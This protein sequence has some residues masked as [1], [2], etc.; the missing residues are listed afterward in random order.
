MKRN[1]NTF[2]KSLTRE[3]SMLPSSESDDD[4]NYIA[5]VE[6]YSEYDMEFNDNVDINIINTIQSN[7][8]SSVSNNNSISEFNL[9]VNSS[10]ISNSSL[11][12]IDNSAINLIYSPD[13]LDNI[14]VNGRIENQSTINS[15]DFKSKLSTL[16]SAH[17]VSHNFCDSLLKLLQTQNLQVPST[18]RTL[19]HYNKYKNISTRILSGVEYYFFGVEFMLINT[20]KLYTNNVIDNI[21][22][23]NISINIDGLPIS[24]STNLAMWPILIL[25]LLPIKHVFPVVV[26]LGRKPDNLDFLKETIYELKHILSNGIK[27]NNKI[28]QIKLSS[29]VCDSPAKCFIKNIRQYNGYYGCDKCTQKGFYYKDVN[30]KGGRMTYPL[31]NESLRSDYS[32]RNKT[33]EN[34][35]LNYIDT[36]FLNLDIH[37]INTFTVDYMHCILLGVTKKLIKLWIRT[38]RK[39]CYRLSY[40]NVSQID[41]RI[42]NISKFLPAVFSR[43]PRS[44]FE[45]DKWKATEFRLFLLYIGK[46]VLKNILQNKYYNH[47]I[48][49]SHAVS[50]IICPTYVNNINL[51]LSNKL[52]IHFIED[53]IQYYGSAFPI[54]NVHSL[55][56]IVNDVKSLGCLDNFSAFPFEN[57]LGALK[58]IIKP[59]KNPLKQVINTIYSRISLNISYNPKKIKYN[60]FKYPNN[61]YLLDCSIVCEILEKDISFNIDYDKYHRCRIY[62]KLASYYR[63]PVTLNGQ[64]VNIDSKSINCY[65]VDNTSTRIDFIEKSKLHKQGILFK[66]ENQFI[67]S[68]ILHLQ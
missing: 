5:N 57:Y 22:T 4:V 10:I 64:N 59:G 20:L 50:L 40:S 14:T 41:A 65:L 15:S 35:H 51:V 54:Y 38:N 29:I 28:I 68:P 1:Y 62:E 56:H 61:V 37:M 42:K 9:S 31:L 55:S 24:K 3:L 52:F 39:H 32:F 46:Y 12:L 66:L 45:Y 8:T 27:Y 58:K 26:T 63:I 13:V 34:H 7:V 60:I 67:F 30:E 48:M 36:P 23:I 18:C 17:N 47:F 11:N 16:I 53:G 25:L 33:D 49:F 21:D 43:K 44:L 19:L 2:Y 6:N